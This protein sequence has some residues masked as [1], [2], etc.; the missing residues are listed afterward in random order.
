MV[1][2]DNSNPKSKG[3]KNNNGATTIK[4]E[5]D[6]IGSLQTS[7]FLSSSKQ[8]TPYKKQ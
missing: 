4:I 1:F 6:N 3:N 8:L 7:F 5:K 2:K